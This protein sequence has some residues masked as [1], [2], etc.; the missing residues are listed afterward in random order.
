VRRKG[1]D[2][3]IVALTDVPDAELV[4]AGGAGAGISIYTSIGM[5]LSFVLRVNE[6]LIASEPATPVRSTVRTMV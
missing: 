3:A 4:V 1:V 2:E 6:P 5:F